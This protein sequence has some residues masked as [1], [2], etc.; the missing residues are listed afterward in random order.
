MCR[1]TE[2]IVRSTLVTAW[3][4]ADCPTST[5]PLRAK[6]TTDG[7]GARALGVGDDRRL[8]ALEDGD[9]GV[10]GPEVDADRTS[11]GGSSGELL[12]LTSAQVCHGSDRALRRTL[13]RSRSTCWSAQRAGWR[14]CSRAGPGRPASDTALATPAAA[15][16]VRWPS[17]LFR[18]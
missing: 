8:A 4:F 11:H 10:G 7:R 15:N 12:E 6:A 16:P 17:A 14:W 13:S 9:D 2:R 5:S 1:L 18:P 3:F